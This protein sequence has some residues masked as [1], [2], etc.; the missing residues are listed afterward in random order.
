[1]LEKEFHYFNEN[2]ENFA[3]EHLGEFIVI[4][5]ETIFGFY[6]DMDSALS[7]MKGHEPGTFFIQQCLPESEI[8]QRYYSRVAI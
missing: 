2:K 1:M 3:K 4:T 7:A 5:G 8:I 6:P